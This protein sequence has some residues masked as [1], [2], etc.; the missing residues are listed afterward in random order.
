[1]ESGARRFSM[2]AP[3][4]RVERAAYDGRVAHLLSRIRDGEVYQANY[5][6][7]FDVA[8]SGD[9][10]ALYEFLVSR[11]Q[12]PYAAYVE[13]ESVSLVSLSP[14]LFLR[15]DGD[16]VHTKPMKGTAP[17]TRID[18]LEN[19]KN[20]AEHLMIVDLLR[21]DLHRV[22]RDVRVP[23]LFDT[24]RYPTFATMTSTV[25]GVLRQDASFADVIRAAF[26]CGSVTGAPKRAAMQH[27]YE[28]EPQARGFYC[29]SI[30]FLSP[31]RRGWWNVPIRTLQFAPGAAA[32]RF[33]AGGGVVSDSHAQTEWEEIFLKARFLA[34]AYD[35]FSIWETLRCG[36]QPSDGAAHVDR[37]A[38][39][40]AMFGWQIEHDALL[41][42]LRTFDGS[43]SAQL[44]RIRASA[45]QV[46]LHAEPLDPTAQPVR[47][48]I[49]SV[50]V[51]S[52]DPLL[53][54][55]TAWRPLHD[56]AAR[57]ARERGCFDALLCNERGEL[58]EGARTTLF[59]RRDG[60]LYTP[61][62]RSGVL[63]GILRSRLVSQADAQER[64]L[65]PAD[66][67]GE[68]AVYVGNSARGLLQ[69]EL[70]HDV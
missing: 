66:I 23:R 17:L 44:V 48:C 2:A 38:A 62:L 14:E 60:V 64:V 12:A 50:R 27:I 37:L 4:S 54:H 11:A 20:R 5:T 18:D 29:G 25:S 52:D 22:C 13:H 8:F 58:T 10:F 63:P 55:K 43:G 9:P 32:A 70:V 45:S 56:A 30:G 15:F 53:A 16:R 19:E 31:R 6:V 68:N 21:N 33:D 61:P 35:R 51:R 1:V 36:P 47:V 46:D 7:P 49:A 28:A 3:L 65:F 26:P 69:A 57:E 41:A 67:R 24:E 39:S 42:R 59:V 40:A 34:P